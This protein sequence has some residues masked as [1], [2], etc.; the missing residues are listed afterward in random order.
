[1]YYSDFEINGLSIYDGAALIKNAKEERDRVEILI[2]ASG[3][4]LNPAEMEQ[5][6]RY[7]NEPESEVDEEKII[8]AD[9]KEFQEIAKML[10]GMNGR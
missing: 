8:E 1:L 4:V 6:S 10:A 9:M 2:M 7:F 3:G 5:Y